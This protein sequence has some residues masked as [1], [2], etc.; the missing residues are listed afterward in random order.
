M[1]QIVKTI[2]ISLQELLGSAIK[3][4]PGIITGLIIL[5]LTR[6]AAEYA[7]KIA[8]K[9][10][11]KALQ[12]KSLQSLLIKTADITAWVVGVVTACIIAFPGLSVGDIIA[13][14]GLSTVA[15]GFTFQDIFK[16]FLAGILILIQRPFHI[17]DQIIV[18][19]YEGTVEQ[20]DIRT[21]R[22]RTYDGERILIPN[23]QV[24]AS[25]VRVRT[26]FAQ[27]RTDLAVAVDYNA[28]LPAVQKI[29][30][31]AIA[32]VEGVLEDKP[33]EIDIV[34]FGESSMDFVVRY[35]THPRQPQVR[36]IQTR[37]IIAVKEALDAA[38]I[39]I[40]YPIRT[41]YLETKVQTNI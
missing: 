7:R 16:N 5:M 3:T 15:I 17:N 13:T 12:S 29:L 25:S 14:L 1:D 2:V 18:G 36:Q 20:I 19:D 22:L 23:A 35:W 38:K 28:S 21:I 41:L 6:Y 34:G 33:P 11:N 39:E 32:G 4:L 27:R 24:F 31:T 9:I 40:P 30:Q 8:E 37:A 10:G 26:A